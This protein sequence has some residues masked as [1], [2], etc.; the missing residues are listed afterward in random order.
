MWNLSAKS[1]YTLVMIAI[2]LLTAL[3]VG[4]V[5]WNQAQQ[6]ILNAQFTNLTGI[7][8]NKARQIENYFDT[9]NNQLI[10]LSE[11]ITVVSAMVQLNRGYKALEET[12]IP[13]E[14][15]DTLETYYSTEF[16]P[17][18][19][20]NITAGVPEYNVFRP[21]S[22]PARY[23]QYH[24]ISN[25]GNAV[26]FKHFADNPEDGSEYSQFHE[27]YHPNMREFLLRFG[28][29]DL[30]LIDFNTGNVVY[31][32]FK[33][34]DYGTNLITGPYRNSGL[35]DVVQ[36]V[37]RDPI[38]EKVQIVD[39]EPYAPSYNAPASFIAAPIFNGDHV[40]GI[41]ALQIPIDQ[42]DAIMTGEGQWAEEG[43][44]STGETYLVGSDLLMRSNSRFIIQ[45]KPSFLTTMRSVGTQD[46]V[47]NLMDRL[48]STVLLQ[49]I[50]TE[51]ARAAL[52]GETDT[53]VIDDYRGV[54]VLSSFSPLEI[55]GLDWVILSEIESEEAFGPVALLL[56]NMLISAAIFIPLVALASIWIAQNFMRPFQTVIGKTK[57]V[58]QA[59][60]DGTLT[61]ANPITFD[62]NAPGEF[63][64][65]GTSMNQI[66]RKVWEKSHE[67]DKKHNDFVD[68]LVRTLPESVAERYKSG[69]KHIFDRAKQATAIF[70]IVRGFRELVS[71]SDSE[72]AF[73][74]SA[75]Y[76]QKLKSLAAEHGVDLFDNVGMEYI[77]VCG[78]TVPYLNFIERT[79]R[80]AQAFVEFNHNF[81][82]KY[83][84]ELNFQ[85][86][87]DFGPMTGGLI[88]AHKTG[89]EV[90]GESIY[91]AQE[92]GYAGDDNSII[93]SQA[94]RNQLNGEYQLIDQQSTILVSG[95][96]QPVWGLDLQTAGFVTSRT[97]SGTIDTIE[98]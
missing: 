17:R 53:R 75:D 97:S 57:E 90:W 79:I 63:G 41:L 43:L 25:N 96:E 19:E 95:V 18:L 81:N 27:K 54:N 44:G 72:D 60:A 61:Q 69:E 64:E 36:K 30:F 83:Q 42:L 33:E 80:F 6:A 68:L 47:I 7:R 73:N 92:V 82:H 50:S 88:T 51:G 5:A 49:K 22:Q 15:N 98:G 37:M 39:F 59:E 52:A 2:A 91:T 21:Q 8:T 1:R 56:R 24:Y 13:L 12:D 67:A 11:D 66:M 9:M 45:D 71:E 62:G 55:E 87:I 3:I 76:D 38:R 94:L 65:L 10:V 93:I 4:Y 28:Y 26:G 78:L 31:T 58:L 23:L 84:T 34:V 89:Y 35:A 86:G 74:L 46:G 32:V 48:N 70:I 20:G 77:G 16:L 29:Y 85:I 40:V 14:F